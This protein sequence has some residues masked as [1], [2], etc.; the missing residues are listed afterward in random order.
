MS[1][2]ETLEMLGI[3]SS[4]DAEGNFAVAKAARGWH[5]VKRRESWAELP[6]VSGE[7]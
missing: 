2:F 6:S 3:L 1:E 7:S 4:G 5:D